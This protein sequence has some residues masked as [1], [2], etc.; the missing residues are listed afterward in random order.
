MVC[1]K[2][3]PAP[4]GGPFQLNALESKFFLKTGLFENCIRGMPRFDF[5]IH[6]D[7]SANLW[8]EPYFMVTF[9]RTDEVTSGFAEK[10]L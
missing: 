3:L 4:Q 8:A 7:V 2:V 9:A 5:G 6:R 10:P 1:R